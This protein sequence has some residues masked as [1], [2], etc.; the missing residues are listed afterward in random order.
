MEIEEPYAH[1]GALSAAVH[2]AAVYCRH[3][4]SH[5]LNGEIDLAVTAIE[6]ALK[7]LEF[8]P[9]QRKEATNDN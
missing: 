6:Q 5:A 4:R 7:N 2:Y 3:A 8:F 9:D 1:L